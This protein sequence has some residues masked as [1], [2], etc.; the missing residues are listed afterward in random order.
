MA[1]G[2][3]SP[4]SSI[5]STASLASPTACRNSPEWLA[6]S[7]AR[8]RTP[9]PRPPPTEAP[10]GPPA[11]QFQGPGGGAEGLAGGEHGGG[12]VGRPDQRGQ[13]ARE[14]VAGQAVPGQF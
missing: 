9:P 6:A 4:S 10:P 11:P 2:S 13:P 3:G 7:A 8:P 14:V 5:A 1:A 12:V